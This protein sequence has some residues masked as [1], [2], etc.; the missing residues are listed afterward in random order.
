MCSESFISLFVFLITMNKKPVPQI[1]S[2]GV[3]GDY[4]NEVGIILNTVV[5]YKE[6][7]K[8]FFNKVPPLKKY[9]EMFS[10]EHYDSVI[11]EQNSEI[12]GKIDDLVDKI[13]T[14]LTTKSRDAEEYLN[15]IN[16]MKLLI[17]GKER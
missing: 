7:G 14:M 1:T 10:L 6:T 4:S 16:H 12:I 8:D 17:Y 13:N 5:F 15:S 3:S 11:T 2:Q 9:T